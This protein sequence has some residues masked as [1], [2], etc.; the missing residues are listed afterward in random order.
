MPCSSWVC[1]TLWA[2]HTQK[3][4]HVVYCAM[5]LHASQLISVVVHVSVA[6]DLYN[7]CV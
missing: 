4:I 1:G 3:A 7:M 5:L 2:V 6:E